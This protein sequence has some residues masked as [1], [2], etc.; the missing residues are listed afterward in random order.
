MG[1]AAQ[2]LMARSQVGGVARWWRTG[3]GTITQGT[4]RFRGRGRRI[5]RA[6]FPGLA[7][8][9]GGGR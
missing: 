1:G 8:A 6:R 9:G 5:S 2:A 3:G 4:M 7:M